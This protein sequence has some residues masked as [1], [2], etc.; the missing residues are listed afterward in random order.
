MQ[1]NQGNLRDLEKCT[2]G[3]RKSSGDNIIGTGVIVTDDGL[4]VTCY[5]VVGNIKT[6]TLDKTVD[7]YF[8]SAPEINGHADVLEE[9][10]DS[11]LDIA[12]LQLQEELPKQVAV[13]NLSETIYP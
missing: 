12:F 13:A 11:S 8:P 7:I 4:I 2:V 6:K 5:H 9:Y 10:S 3:I 1:T